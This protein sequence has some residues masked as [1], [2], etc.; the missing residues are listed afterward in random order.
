M[1]KNMEIIYQELDFVK[2]IDTE[3]AIG[4]VVKVNDET[5]TVDT[6]NLGIQEMN[7]SIL[8]RCNSVGEST[9]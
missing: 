4:H 8:E 1:F 7:K 9:K 5:L 3:K 2:Y 6:T